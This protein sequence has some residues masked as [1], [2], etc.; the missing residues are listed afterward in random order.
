MPE[1]NER[2][3]NL[4]PEKKGGNCIK[5]IKKLLVFVIFDNYKTTLDCIVRLAWPLTVIFCLLVL[6]EQA[7]GLMESL[8]ERVSSSTKIVL[9]EFVIEGK[10]EKLQD[11]VKDKG[12]YG[13]IGSLSSEQLSLALSLCGEDGAVFSSQR[14]EQKEKLDKIQELVEWNLVS[15]ARLSVEEKKKFA[16]IDPKIDTEVTSLPLC[17]NMYQ[18]L[19]D[20][21]I[22]KVGGL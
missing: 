22:N 13:V 17:K 8:S 5:S 19:Q 18:Q 11:L 21:T 15:I 2:A 12:V 10:E 6:R 16:E 9:G 3:C 14:P 4:H 20:L 1:N 7:I